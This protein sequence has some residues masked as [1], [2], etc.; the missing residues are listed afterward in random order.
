MNSIC[1][2]ITF[3]FGWS[4]NMSEWLDQRIQKY[5]SFQIFTHNCDSYNQITYHV[6]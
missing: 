5:I 2:T 4:R 6:F 3:D 1:F